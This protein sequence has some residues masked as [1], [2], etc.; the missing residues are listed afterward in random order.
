VLRSRR[1]GTAT[2]LPCTNRRFDLRRIGSKRIVAV[3]DADRRL[4]ITIAFRA[5][6]AFESIR[7]VCG[8]FLISAIIAKESESEKLRLYSEFIL[9]FSVFGGL[10]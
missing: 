3:H 10:S 1:I 4:P 5:A 9:T 7:I 8:R 6:H 2:K